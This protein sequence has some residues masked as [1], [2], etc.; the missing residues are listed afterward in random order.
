[1]KKIVL[2]LSLLFF[3]FSQIKAD[4]D[5]KA[6]TFDL[7]INGKMPQWG[8]VISTMKADPKF[9]NEKHQIDMLV[10]YYG[11]IGHLID[12]KQKDQASKYLDD[13]NKIAQKLY[14]KN[15][16]SPEL[17]ALM[18]NFTGFQIALKPLKATYLAKGMLDNVNKAISLAP[19]NPVVNIL[20][21]NILFYMPEVFGGDVQKAINGY[22]K[23]QRVFETIPNGTKDNWMY[24][25]LLTTIGLVHE[26]QGNYKAAQQMYQQVMQ[27]HPEY[28]Y[29]KQ[30][31]YPR[32]LT[33]MKENA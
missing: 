2:S 6:R 33:K 23:A 26:K 7:Y 22:K 13:A 5:Y 20:H 15:P 30:V 19:N 4:T 32:L 11:L 31:V 3:L 28:V 1:M 16:K 24:I 21:A 29:M 27:L 8:A 12:K 10:Y 18:G 25:Q 17:L 14:A 9:Q